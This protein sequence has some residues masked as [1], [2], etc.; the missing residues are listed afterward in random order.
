MGLRF[1]AWRVAA[2]AAAAILISAA[3]HGVLGEGYPQSEPKNNVH[4]GCNG[5]NTNLSVYCRT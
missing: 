5:V 3:I 4:S 2:A 1:H